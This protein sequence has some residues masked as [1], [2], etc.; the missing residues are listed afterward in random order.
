MMFTGHRL[1][2]AVS[3]L[4]KLAQPCI[5]AWKN[6]SVQRC[7]SQGQVHSHVYGTEMVVFCDK[8]P[9]LIVVTHRVM[10]YESD[11]VRYRRVNANIGTVH[12]RQA[13][14]IADDH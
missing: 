10:I 8:K 3:P 7:L 9:G 5:S 2:S 4:G 6:D 13:D 11:W 14:D 1:M 12:A